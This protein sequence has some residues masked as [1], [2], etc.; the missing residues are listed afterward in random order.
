MILEF[1][2]RFK[3]VFFLLSLCLSGYTQTTGT[4]K[5][6][7]YD[8]SNGQP[9]P[10]SNVYFKGTTIGAN[11]DLN[12]FFNISRIPPGK[13]TLLITNFDFDTIRESIDLKAGDMINKKFFATKGGVKLQEVE[14]STTSI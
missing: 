14:V 12:G 5:G 6:F 10:F 11:T 3:N 8:K 1:K 2:R 7:I 13:Y 9:I 4:V